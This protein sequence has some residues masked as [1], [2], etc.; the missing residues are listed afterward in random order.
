MQLLRLIRRHE[1]VREQGIRLVILDGDAA[2][3]SF[4]GYV[5]AGHNLKQT[6]G[7]EKMLVHEMEHVRQGHSVDILVLEIL[8]IFQWFN[9]LFWL[10]KRL[11]RENHEYLADRAVLAHEANPANYKRLLVQQFIGPQFELAN[12]FNYLL[13]TTVR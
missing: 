9:P 3:F 5:F 13:I 4:L 6:P 11:L 7:W 8:T 12:N 2:P 1:L 10:L